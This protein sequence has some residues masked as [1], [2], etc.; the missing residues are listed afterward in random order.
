MFTKISRIIIVASFLVI[1]SLSFVHAQDFITVEEFDA[2]CGREGAISVVDELSK[3]DWDN[4][5]WVNILENISLGDEDWIKASACIGKNSGYSNVNV[6]IDIN[7]AWAEA[8][9]KNS[10]AVL[11]LSIMGVS[12]RRICSLPFNEPEREWAAQYVKDTLAAL[13]AISDDATMWNIPIAIERD[14]C[15]MRL[16]DAYAK[17]YDYAD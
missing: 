1:S 5:V 12:L 9:P 2:R 16:K 13:E 3:G 15:I 6:G 17:K 7:I 4:P 8:L 10:Q 14:V 11:A